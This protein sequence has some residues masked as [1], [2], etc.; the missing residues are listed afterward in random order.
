MKTRFGFSLRK[1]PAVVGSFGL[2]LSML[3]TADTAPGP[4]AKV[5]L[6]TQGGAR[7]NL[8]I[9]LDSSGSMDY[10]VPGT[11]DKRI[12][13][14][15]SAAK[16]LIDS[17]EE[18]SMRV[19][20]SRFNGNDGAR[21]LYNLTLL[22]DDEKVDIKNSIDGI[23]ANGITPLAEAASD[24]GRYFTYGYS[25]EGNLVMHPDDSYGQA[26][27][28][29]QVD[30]IFENDPA[31]SWNLD[32]S[33][34]VTQYYCQK[35][36]FMLLT[37]GEPNGDF[38]V[39]DSLKDYD[40]DCSD[41]NDADL[42]DDTNC[43]TH[44]RGDGSDYLDDVTT[45]MF[46]M[47][48]RPDLDNTDTGEEVKNNVSSYMVGFAEG[49]LADNPLLE[50]AASQAGG[51]Y[52]YAS[53]SDA[54]QNAFRSI[55]TDIFSKVGSSSA[56]SFNA[57]SYR[58]GA[59]IYLASYNSEKWSGSLVA[60]QIDEEGN[61]SSDNLWAAEDQLDARS[62]STRVIY[63]W[64]EDVGKVFGNNLIGVDPDN[65]ITPHQEDLNTNNY[66]ESND[67]QATERLAYLRGVTAREGDDSDDFR[68][69]DTV[70]G[71]I[72]NSTPVHVGAPN[73]NYPDTDPFGAADKRYS[74]FAAS[75]AS[76]NEVVYVGSNDGMLH[77]FDTDTG[78]EVMAYVPELVLSTEAN[79][80]L[81]YL[82]SQNYAHKFYV[83]LTPTIAD[84]Y[85][86]DAW[87]TVLVGGL[88]AGGKGYFF[89][90]VTDPA[91]FTT[92]NANTVVLDEIGMDD[93]DMGLSFSQPKVA[94]LN[95]G[96]WAAIFGNGYNSDSG[97]AILYL[98]YFDDG[99][100]EKIDTGWTPP[101]NA[102][103]T[104]EKSGLS[105]PSLADV[106]GDGVVDRV[107]AGDVQGNMWAFDLCNADLGGVCQDSGW[108]RDYGGPLFTTGTA[109]NPEP[110]TT[111]PRIAKNT[112]QPTGSAPNLM[113]LFG[114]GQYLNSDDLKDTDGTAYYGVWDNGTG[115][116][117][118]TNLVTRNFTDSGG[119]RRL[120]GD[121]VN[122]YNGLEG[123][124]GWKMP[125]DSGSESATEVTGGERVITES[126]L[127]GNVLFFN[128]A[129]PSTATCSSGGTGYLMSVDF[130]S[131]VAPNQAVF[132]G[133][134]DGVIDDGDK[135]YVGELASDLGDDDD[136]ESGGDNGAGNGGIPNGPG[137][138]SGSNGGEGKLCLNVNGVAVC[139][140]RQ[141][142]VGKREGRLSW[143]EISPF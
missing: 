22:T 3:A 79:E 114:S 11:W 7:P 41:D 129:I 57:T 10:N 34:V 87:H 67:G 81:H 133:N 36:F 63:T 136:G 98:Y 40:G 33:P 89:L 39:S 86:D 110:I 15:K 20:L 139:G 138:I 72:V 66:T 35:N 23:P 107:Y 60:K 62:A 131:G 92:G 94:L 128:T 141:W 101:T 49:S 48:L 103:G 50:S 84:A 143:Q 106:N 46:D 91:D 140:P 95:N 109:D 38:G 93:E 132:D 52:L 24:I 116:L 61:I 71:D 9:M 55:L 117:N 5:P 64:D 108:E 135:G 27:S 73:F 44:Y 78:E 97:K 122:W 105:T 51:E 127:L 80:G 4:I 13:V 47:D 16:G 130:L 68:R 90:D 65:P 85:F 28:T 142:Y 21:I 18:G 2:S 14:V 111:S 96:R 124:Y 6:A 125:L 37:D 12:D 99:T 43:R 121:P 58:D 120:T 113:V 53:N 77:G 19:G 102:D 30:Q 54:L 74:A 123:D 100:V 134:G 104:V 29:R 31:Y 82:T 88:G 1:L 70:L 115:G 42:D 25:Q 59:V 32:R 17:L 45:A 76:R 75:Q 119:L 83:N 8:M 126:I 112:Q 26:A 137:F 56:A 118:S 69:R